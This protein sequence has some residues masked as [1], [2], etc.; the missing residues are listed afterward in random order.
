M[1]KIE[2]VSV[3]IKK[4]DFSSYK[5]KFAVYLTDGRIVIVPISMFPGIKKL[6]VERRNTWIIMDDQFFTFDHVSEIYPVTDVL[7]HC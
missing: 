4:L 1:C 7:K 5:G 3:G 2:G 6:S